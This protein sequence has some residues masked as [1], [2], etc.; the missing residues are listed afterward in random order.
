MKLRNR[1]KSFVVQATKIILMLTIVSMMGCKKFLE[2]PPPRTELV[3]S[4][5]FSSPSTANGVVLGMYSR[6]INDLGF[7]YRISQ[8][9]GMAGDEH[10]SY[11]TVADINSFYLDNINSQNRFISTDLWNQPYNFIY[12]ANSILEGVNSSNLTS[13]LKNQLTGEAKFI[14][15]FWHFYLVNLYGAIPLVT[16]TEY[17]LNGSMA[18]TA[19]A[20]VYNQIIADLKDAQNLLNENYVSA[21]GLTTSAERVRPNKSVAT[22]LLARVYLYNNDFADAEIE[23]TKIISQSTYSLV[24]NLS[25]VFLKNSNE[26]IW[27]LQP[28]P[29]GAFATPEGNSYVLTTL[30]NA[31]LDSKN[32]TI[33]SN[34]LSAFTSGDNRKTN[35]IGD[36]SGYKFPN[37]YKIISGTTL[38][39]YSIVFR[40]AEQYLIRGEARAQQ[41]KL[42]EGLQDV[43][44]IRNRAG[45]LDTTAT[46]KDQL[47][48]IILNERRLEL[49]SE[50]GHRWFDLKRMGK[51]D[52]VMTVVTPQKGTSW[53]SYKK[54]FPLPKQSLDS[55]PNLIQNPGY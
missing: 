31:N 50:Y 18:R 51:I 35:W 25:L 8:L 15:A 53:S 48:D 52:Q 40:L 54:L 6:M 29:S 38:T 47:L 22:A 12:N 43:N 7:P 37:K 5:V 27:A 17:T 21:D 49:F 23:A 2:I 19:A 39:E 46:S 10:Q 41:N 26:T 28:A 34:L 1:Q 32:L 13:Q 30:P 45:L 14:R 16:S 9:T 4:S 33:S 36:Y 42:L 24:S 20:D 55:D 11:S 3:S 44:K